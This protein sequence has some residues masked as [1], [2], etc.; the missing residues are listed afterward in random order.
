MKGYF[1]V[2]YNIVTLKKKIPLILNILKK[3]TQEL[4][5]PNVIYV[6]GKT[7]LT[8]PAKLSSGLVHPNPD[9]IMEMTENLTKII[10]DH[11]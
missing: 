5:L 1:L 10:K 11:L 3:V 9:G 6:N 4:N 8:S 7:V 2:L